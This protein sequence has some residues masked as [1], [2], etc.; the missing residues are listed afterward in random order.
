MTYVFTRDT[1]L[2]KIVPTL[3]FS[4]PAP[5]D[6]SEAPLVIDEQTEEAEEQQE[7][8]L[9]QDDS[10][11]EPLPTPLP[12][13]EQDN[14]G[15]EKTPS[16]VGVGQASKGVRMRRSSEPE[17]VEIYRSNVQGARQGRSLGKGRRKR[18]I[19]SDD[20]FEPKRE[21]KAKKAK[22]DSDARRKNRRDEPER[23]DDSGQRHSSNDHGK[24]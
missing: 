6:W 9:R 14:R 20:D 19:E 18:R 24:I 23:R 15:G 13:H 10:I 17:V 7:P 1:S 8:V 2:E 3:P 12:L 22:V 21:K 11:Q 16:L 4:L 5:S